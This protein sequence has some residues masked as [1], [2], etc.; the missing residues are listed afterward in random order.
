MNHREATFA[1]APHGKRSKIT[2]VR[3]PR[4]AGRH[5]SR[6][7]GGH[8][9]GEARPGAAVAKVIG[10]R[11]TVKATRD[12]LEYVLAKADRAEDDWAKDIQTPDQVLRDWG[13]SLADDFD[14]EPAVSYH[15][16]P[17]DDPDVVWEVAEQAKKRARVSAHI[18][19][20]LPGNDPEAEWDVARE[21]ARE[22]FPDH[23]YVC[24]LHTDTDSAHVHLVIRS[25]DYSGRALRVN[26]EDLHHYRQVL[27]RLGRQRGI[28]VEARRYDIPT[29]PAK[30]RCLFPEPIGKRLDR[31]VAVLSSPGQATPTQLAKAM[32]FVKGKRKYLR[33]G[34]RY[35]LLRATSQLE[36]YPEWRKASVRLTRL[37]FKGDHG[38]RF[39]ERHELS[40]KAQALHEQAVPPPSIADDRPPEVVA[41][42]N[43]LPPRKIRR[44]AK[45][46][47]RNID[48]LRQKDRDRLAESLNLLSGRLRRKAERA[49]KRT[50]TPVEKAREKQVR[51]QQS[52]AKAVADLQHKH[53]SQEAKCWALIVL[54]WHRRHL[55][56]VNRL[57]LRNVH[58]SFPDEPELTRFVTRSVEKLARKPESWAVKLARATERFVRDRAHVWSQPSRQESP[59]RAVIERA[60]ATVESDRA[61]AMARARAAQTLMWHDRHLSNDDRRRITDPHVRRRIDAAITVLGQPEATTAA[62]LDACRAL[63]FYRPHM[64]SA[65][66]LAVRQAELGAGRNA[67]STQRLTALIQFLAQPP[68]RQQPAIDR[69]GTLRPHQRDAQLAKNADEATKHDVHHVLSKGK[70]GRAWAI[71]RALQEAGSHDVAASRAALQVLFKYRRHLTERDHNDLLDQAGR[72]RT[73]RLGAAD[74]LARLATTRAVLTHAPPE[75][76]GKKR[77]DL[78]RAVIALQ[79]RD[80]E[81]REVKKA[82]KR[83]VGSARLLTRDQR[84]DVH[85]SLLHHCGPKRARK[86]QRILD[87]HRPLRDAQPRSLEAQQKYDI[88]TALDTFKHIED[89]TPTRIY[90][91]ADALTE[92]REHLSDKQRKMLASVMRRVE[93]VAPHVAERLYPVASMPVRNAPSPAEL[94]RNKD[95]R[96]AF[97]VLANRAALPEEVASARA[98]L[99]QHH[100]KLSEKQQAFFAKIEDR[101]DNGPGRRAVREAFDALNHFEDRHPKYI[102][103]AGQTLLEHRAELS[104]GQLRFLAAILRRLDRAAPMVAE[105]LYEL[106]P[107]AKRS[108]DIRRAFDALKDITTS[109]ADKGKAAAETLTR[110]SKTLSDGQRR[111]LAAIVGRVESAA[112]SVADTLYELVPEA[113]RTRDI[114]SALDTLKTIGTSSPEAAS[115]AAE[116]LATHAESLSEGQR[117]FLASIVRRV[118]PVAP[119]V[120]ERLYELVPEAKRT[121]DISRAFD[122]LKAFK[123]H[124]PEQRQAAVETFIT[125]S[126]TLSEKQRRFVQALLTRVQRSDPELARR[127]APV[128]EESQLTVVDARPPAAP[129]STQQATDSATEERTPPAVADAP[130]RTSQSHPAADEPRATVTDATLVES[131]PREPAQDL[132]PI[133]ESAKSAQQQPEPIRTEP[134][135]EPFQPTPP[136]F[137]FPQSRPHR[138]LEEQV[139]QLQSSDIGSSLDAARFLHTYRHDLTPKQHQAIVDAA[140]T[141]PANDSGLHGQRSQLARQILDLAPKELAAR[142]RLDVALSVKAIAKPDTPSREVKRAIAAIRRHSQHVTDDHRRQLQRAPLHQQ[143]RRNQQALYTILARNRSDRDHARPSRTATEHLATAMDTIERFPNTSPERRRH[144]LTALTTLSHKLTDA[145]KQTLSA[146]IPKLKSTHPHIAR[147]LAAIPKAPTQT[148]P[149]RNR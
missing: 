101:L 62:K 53:N 9:Q 141:W 144:A 124:S 137:H 16:R 117:R 49:L 115:S 52:I 65:D 107:E 38:K 98:T 64:S 40:Q 68:A 17:S 80:L 57:A 77:F 1:D 93:R 71:D 14:G 70:R 29:P 110:H 136:S 3:T 81:P 41:E 94:Q 84:D 27:A 4:P 66:R 11:T 61:P 10:H 143:D 79:K 2:T 13:L 5:G 100:E 25:R 35:Q 95:I 140:I 54:W 147:R 74:H 67:A 116:T 89:S 48:H 24:A 97:D 72:W 103:P 83:V 76:E 96:A 33:D 119:S 133:T 58:V 120:D 55:T 59:G 138:L 114:R 142:A 26:R 28:A 51:R 87:K 46:L 130:E 63:V 111:F 6:A 102:A 43:K 88:R 30:W 139:A 37:A 23:P 104:D 75:L 135:P 112:P 131:P 126:D 121:R 132:V 73:P 127:L 122:T 129:E 69:A 45:A 91:A 99:A 125:H 118:E 109:T 15:G 85:Q 50:K 47:I 90:V 134:E 20:S 123:A 148:I 22:C 145:Q 108:R 42:L 34:H 36:R 39:R 32:R 44:N 78:Q 18:T 86:L 146:H 82:I 19:F 12:T 56:A 21:A 60:V 105:E 113:K 8:G 92:H 7:R 31:H 149:M 106:V 128:T